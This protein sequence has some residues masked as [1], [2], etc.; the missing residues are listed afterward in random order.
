[1]THLRRALKRMHTSICDVFWLL[2]LT[3]IAGLVFV[4][5]VIPAYV[6]KFLNAV[7]CPQYKEKRNDW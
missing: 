5:L 2:V 4:F 1:M 3:A 6:G 7:F